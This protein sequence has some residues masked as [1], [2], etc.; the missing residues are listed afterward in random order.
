MENPKQE[1][2]TNEE[3]KS[4]DVWSY[5]SITHLDYLYYHHS[6]FHYSKLVF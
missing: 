6:I 4:H 5:P 3:K 1:K 2:E